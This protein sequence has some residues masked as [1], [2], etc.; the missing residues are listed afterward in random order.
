MSEQPINRID[1]DH[2]ET[3]ALQIILMPD[4]SIKV[5]SPLITD[6]MACYGLLEVAKDAIK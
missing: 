6:K 5:V 2:K 1:E 4:G 3:V